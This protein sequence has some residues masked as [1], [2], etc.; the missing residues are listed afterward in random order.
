VPGARN[1]VNL[2]LFPVLTVKRLPAVLV[3]I[4]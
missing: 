3:A 4:T 1:I 2:P